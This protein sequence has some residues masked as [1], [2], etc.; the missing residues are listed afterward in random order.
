MVWLAV[1]AYGPQS[2]AI[3]PTPDPALWQVSHGDTKIYLSGLP[4]LM[5]ADTQWR[6]AAFDAAL[7]EAS[8]FILEATGYELVRR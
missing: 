1:S 5:D 7:S 4:N 6:S 8:A 3:Q 2:V